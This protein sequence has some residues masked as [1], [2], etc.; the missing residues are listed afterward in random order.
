M[1]RA[2][3]FTLV[4]LLVV[5]AIIALLLSILMPS[6]RK[7]RKQARVV[8]CQANLRQWGLIWGSYTTDNDGKFHTGWNFSGGDWDKINRSLWMTALRPHYREPKIRCCP[9]ASNPDKPPGAFGTWGPFDGS[10][11]T[12][13]G[14]YGS[15]GLNVFVCNP[16]GNMWQNIGP[17]GGKFWRH[18]AVRGANKV[19]VFLDSAW[20]RAE[21]VSHFNPP[22]EV[23]GLIEGVDDL[24]VFCINRHNETINALLLDWS[25]TKVG[26]KELWVLKWH[27]EF[28]TKGPYTKV[29]GFGWW[30]VWMKNMRDY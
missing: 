26:L 25:V 22:P 2:R 19:P 18:V 24:S 7:A 13:E 4:E 10:Q 21:Q 1:K 6:L 23:E 17:D 20:T 3:G 14:D 30:P 12:T 8:V 29:G 5:I 16:I 27:R 9:D 28:D 11:W 15:Y